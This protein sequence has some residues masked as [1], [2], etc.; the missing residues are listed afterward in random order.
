MM[1][2]LCGYVLHLIQ[3]DTAAV[4]CGILCPTNIKRLEIILS[5]ALELTWHT[6]CHHNWSHFYFP[7]ICAF[8]A[9]LCLSFITV[10]HVTCILNQR[11]QHIYLIRSYNMN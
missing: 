9:F 1:Y 2:E 11:H 6:F 10:N 4:H 8:V 3:S 5:L 7:Y